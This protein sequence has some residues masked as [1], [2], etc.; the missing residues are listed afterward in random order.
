MG[1]LPPLVE[2]EAP[3]PH[4]EIP[5]VGASRT[6]LGAQAAVETAPEI[7]RV[8]QDSIPRSD[9][10]VPDHFPWKML[11]DQRADGDAGAAVETFEGRVGAETLDLVGELRIHSS[12]E[13]SFPV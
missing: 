10:G 9:L 11:M 2:N 12:H 7:L 6:G 8:F 13:S 4:D 1:G 3:K 5:R